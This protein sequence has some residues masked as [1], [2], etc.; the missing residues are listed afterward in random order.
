MTFG[1]SPIVDTVGALGSR[2]G[3]VE[4]AIDTLYQNERMQLFVAYVDVFENPADAVA[5]TDATATANG[6]GSNDY[7]LAVAVDGHSYYLSAASGSPL[8]DQ[9]LTEIDQNYIEPALHDADWAGAAIGAAT[10]LERAARGDSLNGGTGGGSG[11]VWFFLIG[12]VI[13]GAVLFIVL[14][15]RGK[16]SASGG[17][18]GAA[19]GGLGELST[20][21]LKQRAGSALVRTD[22]AVKTS[23]EELGFAIASYGSEATAGFQKALADA[24]ALLSNGFTLQQKLD[25][26]EPDTEEQ[27]RSW[28]AQIIDLCEKANAVLDAQAEAFDALRALEK[29]AP[30]A[31]AT[32]RQTAE[33]VRGRLGA[34][35]ATVARLATQYTDA[36]LATIADNPAQAEDRLAFAEAA[37][38]Q[39]D[40]ALAAG[41]TSDAAVGIR[42]G[43][44]AVDQA[45]LLLDAVDRLDHDL[46]EARA[47]FSAAIDD[48]R[49]D[50]AAA[51]ALPAGA[52]ASG[53]LDSVVAATEAVLSDVSAKLSAERVNPVE[54]V[55]RLEQANNQIDTVLGSVRDAQA[56]QARAEAALSQNLLAARSQLSAAEDFITA[57]RGA[58]G[59]EARTRLAEAGRLIV[60]AESLS[61]ADPAQALGQAQRAN[62]LAA[63]AI[64]LAQ[65]DVGGYGGGM[66][67]G[68]GGDIFGSGSGRGGGGNVAGAVLGGLLINSMLG[69]G[70]SRGSSGGSFGGSMGGA[71]VVAAPAVSGAAAPAPGAALAAVSDQ[72]ATPQPHGRNIRKGNTLWL[73][74]PSS[75]ASPSSR[76]RTSTL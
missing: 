62:Q 64:R 53:Q 32:A 27:Q 69:G 56:A 35:R 40:T 65:N 67:T 10:G 54:V 36:A 55:R 49:S 31:L 41:K 20:A 9:Q 58:V 66:G 4:K 29:N 73:S 37:L 1:S 11:F 16:S 75:V 39:A 23:E 74:S 18:G 2:T 43:E 46:T 61:A 21:E 63:E 44:E 68:M 33:T 25:D 19:P 22:D 14:R 57:R 42:A 76:R 15:R 59:A 6:L 72:Q 24:K 60:Q 52:D 38:G 5:W 12:V 13:V 51:R 47:S 71:A 48:L 34:A 50:I 70:G 3:D 8:S 45:A 17:R 7:L 26:S 28:Y 30:Q